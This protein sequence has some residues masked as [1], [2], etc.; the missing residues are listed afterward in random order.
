[1]TSAKDTPARRALGM[2][3]MGAGIAGS[4]LGYALQRAFLGKAEGEARLKS[5]HTRAARP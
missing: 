1:M 3:S 5:T 4:Y 2:A